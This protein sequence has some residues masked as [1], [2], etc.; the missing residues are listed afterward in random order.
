M[1]VVYISGSYR[2]KTINGVYENI[3]AARKEALKW[4]KEGYAVI[5]PHMNTALMDGACDDSVWLKGDLELLRRSDMVVMLEGWE[6]SE[7]AKAEY[8]E[9][10]KLN[11]FAIAQGETI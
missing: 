4:W 6:E 5:C 11:I 10:I 1:K 3:Q 7:G 2:S 9:A 8:R